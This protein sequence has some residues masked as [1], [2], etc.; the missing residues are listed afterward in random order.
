MNVTEPAWRTSEHE[1]TVLRAMGSTGGFYKGGNRVT[2][3][4]YKPSLAAGCIET[5]YR[6]KEAMFNPDKS[7]E[8]PSVHT[9]C[10]LA[11]SLP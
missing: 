3:V 4:F 1:N 11:G 7:P 5:D 10:S 2:F 9:L 8:P 6:V